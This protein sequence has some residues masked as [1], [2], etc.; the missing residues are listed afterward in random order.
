MPYHTSIVCFCYQNSITICAQYEPFSMFPQRDEICLRASNV[1]IPMIP[2][3]FDMKCWYTLKLH[4]NISLN[5]FIIQCW[6]IHFDGLV[7][8]HGIAIANTM[9]YCFDDRFFNKLWCLIVMLGAMSPIFSLWCNRDH[10][11]CFSL[12]PILMPYSMIILYFHLPYFYV[13]NNALFST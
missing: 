5:V 9:G 3:L 12:F 4:L 11:C 2:V 7:Q 1:F 10:V 8:D 13:S 6:Y